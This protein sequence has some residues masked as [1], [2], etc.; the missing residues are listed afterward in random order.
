MCGITGFLNDGTL[1]K[2]DARAVLQ[3]MTDAIRH[4]KPD[5]DGLWQSD[6]GVVNLGHRRLSILDLSPTGAQPMVS[7]EGRYVISFNGEIYNFPELRAELEAAGQGFRGTSDTEVLL[8]GIRQWGVTAILPR[9]NGM[10]AFA[11]WDTRD[12]KLTLA[13]DRFGEKPLYYAWHDGVLL[14]GSELKALAEHPAFRREINTAAL[15]QLLRFNYV[16]WPDCIFKNAWKMGPGHVVCIKPGQVPPEPTPFWSL[17]TMVGQRQLQTVDARDPAL[18][19]Q[20][21]VTMKRAVLDRM[22]SDVPLGA[23]LSGGIDSSTIVAL[24]Q[25]Q[26]ARP[27]KTFT[28]GFWEAPFNEADD[29][30][31][32]A[33]HLGTEHHELYLSN[34]ECTDVIATLPRIYDE[35]F[36][37]SSQIPTALVSRFTRKHVTVA[38]SG[39]AGDE[40]FGGY[41]RYV[42]TARVWPR[43]ARMPRGFRQRLALGI[44]SFSP[45]YWEKWFA[46]GN[47]IVPSRFRVR[48]GG[49]KLH[50]LAQAM[51]ASSVDELY[52]GFV[53]QWQNP[54]EVL[55]Q[56]TEPLFLS[57]HI[58][59]IPASIDYIERMM[60][61]DS[62]TYLPSDILCK[63]D[64]ASMASGLETRIPFLDNNVV[65]LAWNMPLDVKIHRGVS[66]WPLRQLLGRYVPE[67]LFSRPK[68]GFGIPIDSWLR[69]PLRGWAEEMLD[70]RR[71]SE[72]GYFNVSVVRHRW[73]EHL[74]GRRNHQHLLWI[75]MMFEAWRR[76]WK[77]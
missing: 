57:R 36:A 52:K 33:R 15:A 10:F 77:V 34:R 71:L 42:W 29:A 72:S 67:E 17:S 45:A 32:V 20:L 1:R 12:R 74:A 51:G 47:A 68:M 55:V 19:D 66:K 59:Q 22:V 69:G 27:I 18:I 50:K 26:S 9:L 60:Y 44:H 75:V 41:N 49:E 25:A 14:F 56:G 38:L 61:L 11:L 24:M 21:D 16:P 2:E 54:S 31:Q 37:D 23:F 76:E 58:E 5:A 8:Q 13:R 46:L 3:R 39:D 30:A 64:R 35:P 4:R 28:I 70:E 6:D 48:G 62:V 43:L 7:A 73:S 65:E 53:S 63:V 40:M